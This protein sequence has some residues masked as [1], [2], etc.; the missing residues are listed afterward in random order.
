MDKYLHG[1]EPHEQ[2]RLTRLQGLLNASSLRQL[3]INGGERVLDVGS[4]LGN[5]S[6][7]MAR[8]GATVLGI[9]RDAAQ[10]AE[11]RRQAEA[12]S[13]G[14]LIEVRQGAAAS[15]PLSDDEWGSF[16]IAHG[17]FILE[18]VRDPQGV[19]DAMM[20]AVRPGGR[21]VLEDDDH[22]VMRLWPE[23]PEFD[24]LWRAYIGAYE[25]LG[26]DPYVGRHLV[27]MLHAAG[28][29][30]TR[31]R[32][33]NFGGCHDD[34]AF[35]MLVENYV[36]I[37]EGAR[38]GIVDQG[39]MTA[40][41]FDAAIAAFR[42]WSAR[43]DASM[44]YSTCW[45]EGF[46]PGEDHGARSS[47]MRRAKRDEAATARASEGDVLP[48]LIATA[49]DLNSTLELPEVFRRV[50]RRVKALIDCHLFFVLLWNDRDGLLEH[51]YSLRFDS[52]VELRDAGGFPL[53]HGIG[54]TAAKLRRPVRVPNVLEDPRYVRYRAQ[55]LEIHSELAVPLIVKDRL[56]G[57]IDL[58]S[59]E[60]GAFTEE[61][62]QVL[63]ALA[64]H[65]AIAVE[66]AKLY[67]TVRDDEARLEH[68][69]ATAREIQKALLPV[70]CQ[71]VPGLD[72]GAAYVPALELGGDFY[73]VLSG[74]EGRWAF[75]VG[76]VAGKATA[77]ALFG[78]MALGIMRGNVDELANTPAE[79]L[80]Y[81]NDQLCRPS[82]EDRFIAMAFCLFDPERRV[83]TCG[84]GG[85]PQPWLV[86]GGTAEPVD[87]IGLALGIAEGEVYETVEIALQPGDVVVL[88]SD[89][90]IEC[91]DARGEMFGTERLAEALVALADRSA[92]DIADDLLAA[93]DSFAAGDASRH[94][95][96]TALVLKPV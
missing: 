33:L 92:Q 48:F 67:E 11:S 91:R 56:V 86:R 61:H 44:W 55:D 14:H 6:R 81:L 1:T 40:E 68:D 89:G 84:N 50:A 73:D 31:A 59:M 16:D 13:E 76:D 53:G 17:R 62:E 60:Y 66:N 15:P 96:R 47:A 4:G 95:D 35:G 21:L 30:E 37:I 45:A 85:F 10:I 79:M 32:Q 64:S 22:D 71:S 75:A 26:A 83:L 72:V 3:A 5:L 51:S 93:T 90:F 70:R 80:A 20:R 27:S 63:M 78:S 38:E 46:R 65:I 41:A 87:V 8:K 19:V 24:A 54:G 7:A 49:E 88:C 74:P 43:P 28:A 36:G 9:E 23:L 42:A 58:E 25:D 39:R 57:V 69:L 52:L 34:P 29:E 82:I 77:A 12:S 94:D 18:H 2:R